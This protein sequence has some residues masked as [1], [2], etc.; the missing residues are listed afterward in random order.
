MHDTP[1]L[2]LFSWGVS[3]LKPRTKLGSWLSFCCGFHEIEAE[4][5]EA[6]PNVETES[7]TFWISACSKEMEEKRNER[8]KLQ[9]FK[10]FV[11]HWEFIYK[12][13]YLK[14]P[15][16]QLERI[17]KLIDFHMAI[18]ICHDL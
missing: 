11:Y 7:I 17:Q 6:F 15:I 2:E 13:E 4:K 16:L 18:W 9:L 5:H 8:K 3:E 14:L 12:T 1:T 10:Q